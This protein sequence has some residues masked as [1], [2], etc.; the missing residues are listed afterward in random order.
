MAEKTPEQIKS[1]AKAK[2]DAEAKAK[3]PKKVNHEKVCVADRNAKK[4]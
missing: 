4:K 1:E 2:A 3:A